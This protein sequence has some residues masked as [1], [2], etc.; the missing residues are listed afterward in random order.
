[1]SQEGEAEFGGW[2]IDEV[3]YNFICDRWP[4]GKSILEFGSGRG[5]KAL[6]EHYV[7]HS[8]EH[9]IRWLN[10]YNSNYIF[11]PLKSHKPLRHYSGTVW[12]D[13]EILEESIKSIHYDL[14]L[15]DGPPGP[16]RAG[17]LKY[18]DLFDLDVPIIFDDVHRKSAYK[19]MIG[20]SAKLKQPCTIYNAHGSKHFG[21]ID[22][23]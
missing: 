20:F 22:R 13:P 18:S 6:A 21:F 23:G 7:V 12:Y 14:I 2:S 3:L 16:N 5:T 17:F 9:D 4:K 8:V 11:A 10:K 19:V 1:M 15:V